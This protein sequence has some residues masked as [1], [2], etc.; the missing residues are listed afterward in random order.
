MPVI[1]TLAGILVSTGFFNGMSIAWKA[2]VPFL[3]LLV[4]AY[5]VVARRRSPQRLQDGTPATM[6]SAE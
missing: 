6:E 3:V 5:M 1:C 4:I 2:G